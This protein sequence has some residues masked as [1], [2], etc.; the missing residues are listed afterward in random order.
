E[1]DMA[2]PYLFTFVPGQE[3]RTQQLV[4]ALLDSEFHHRPDGLPGNDDA[5]A[6]S[7]WYV[8][9]AMGLYPSCPASNRFEIGTPLFDRVTIRV[10]SG[11]SFTIATRRA[12]P[13]DAYV[14]SIALDGRR[15]SGFHLTHDALVRGGT[16]LVEMS[17]RP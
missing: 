4:R 8:W 10:A 11:R 1:P 17:P 5:G 16:L 15:L 12:S 14:R 3:W 2:H 9:S 6:L 7:A 13:G